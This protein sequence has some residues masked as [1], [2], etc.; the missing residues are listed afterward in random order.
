M[1]LLLIVHF[2]LVLRL[3][4]RGRLGWW[5]HIVVEYSLPVATPHKSTNPH[6]AYHAHCLP[7]MGMKDTM[8]LMDISA[9]HLKGF[10]LSLSYRC[11]AIY[12]QVSPTGPGQPIHTP[13]MMMIWTKISMRKRTV[14]AVA[15]Y[16]FWSTPRR[17]SSV[18][19]SGLPGVEGQS[20]S[21]WFHCIFTPAIKASP[22]PYSTLN[23]VQ[24]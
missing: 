6:I 1:S 19:K 17:H 21:A 12:L 18:C 2:P 14:F 20:N 7:L 13:W 3:L 4:G 11:F 22:S 9:F 5:G 16:W 10:S 8:I 24:R 15:D 23:L